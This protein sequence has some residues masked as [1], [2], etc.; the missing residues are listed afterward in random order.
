MLGDSRAERGAYRGRLP[1]QPPHVAIEHGDK[2]HRSSRDDG[3][4]APAAREHGDLAED[5]ARAE[6]SDNDSVSK[7]VGVPA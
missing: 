5:I 1:L 7:D 2:A 4:R 3:S 6:R